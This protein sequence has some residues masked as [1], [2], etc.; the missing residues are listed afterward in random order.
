MLWG[1]E[2]YNDFLY[3]GKKL[4]TGIRRYFEDR[5]NPNSKETWNTKEVT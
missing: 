1:K 4:I 3:E 2:L 5:G